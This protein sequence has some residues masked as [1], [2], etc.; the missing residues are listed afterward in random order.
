MNENETK[1]YLY[2][3]K[4]KAILYEETN[5]ALYYRVIAKDINLNFVVPKNDMG[6]A[7]FTSVMDAQL[8]IR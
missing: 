3:E 8:L 6:T 4:P 5:D 2:K 7:R 1:K